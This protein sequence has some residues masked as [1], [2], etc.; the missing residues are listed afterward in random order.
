MYEALLERIEDLE[1]AV[2]LIEDERDEAKRD[3]LPAELVARLV[4]GEHPVRIWCYH[5]GLKLA[6]L[7]ANSG[8]AASYVSEI[9]TGKKPGSVAAIRKLAAGLKVEVDDLIR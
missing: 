3:Y 6:E 1:D 9:E 4:A 5:R 7:A 2:R 8:V